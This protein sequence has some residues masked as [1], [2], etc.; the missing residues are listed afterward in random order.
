MPPVSGLLLTG[1]SSRR[2]GVDK[3]TLVV[4]GTTLAARGARVLRAVCDPVVEV[5]FG[6]SELP[7]V[8]EDPPS[9]GPLAAVAAGA[10]ELAR[11]GAFGATIV[12]AVDLPRVST[13]L[14]ELLRDWPGEPTVIPLVDGRRQLVC[15]RYGADALVAARSL[16]A[17]GVSSLRELLDVVDHDVLDESVWGAVATADVLADVDSPADAARLGIAL[18]GGPGGRRIP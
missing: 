6:S 3:A 13:A 14:L 8:R 4:D 2:L 7:S 1:G 15:A 16:L 12:L 10:D 17:G 9:G 5:G 18:D 11:R